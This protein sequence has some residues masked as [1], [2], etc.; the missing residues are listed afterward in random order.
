MPSDSS[1]ASDEKSAPLRERE[2][3][4]TADSARARRNEM[5]AILCQW[6]VFCS[7]GTFIFWKTHA[8]SIVGHDDEQI[9]HSNFPRLRGAVRSLG[10]GSGNRSVRDIH[11]FI[12]AEPIS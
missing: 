7:Y 2:R 11:P 8:N 6:Y 4:D 1:R 10:I 9:I 3:T 12:N 5:G